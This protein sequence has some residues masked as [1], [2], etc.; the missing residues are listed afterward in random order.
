MFNILFHNYGMINGS[1]F[2][3]LDFFLSSRFLNKECRLI[4]KNFNKNQLIK[5][6]AYKYIPQV[7]KY[8]NEIEEYDFYK[9]SE[10]DNYV[11][12]DYNTLKSSLFFKKNI[13]YINNS[14]GNIDNDLLRKLKYIFKTKLIVLNEMPFFDKF[15]IDYI[16]DFKDYVCKIGLL[17]YNRNYL[18]EN[19]THDYNLATC[20]CSNKNEFNNLYEKYISEYNINEF[21]LNSYFYKDNLL[22]KIN[23]LYVFRT[24]HIDRKPNLPI[25]CSYLNIPIK[26]ISYS[27]DN[28]DDGAYYR[29]NDALNRN[30]EKYFI[31]DDD[32]I[33]HYFS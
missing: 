26:Y 27:N 4:I 13:I 29:T 30:F 25:E 33:Y 2:N 31:T 18:I 5:I 7:L 32:L 17:I 12:F 3:C 16:Y 10:N 22:L 6:A 28:L 11:I 23:K 14:V 20:I 24:P 1:L 8:F 21:K 15:H 19:N 9:I